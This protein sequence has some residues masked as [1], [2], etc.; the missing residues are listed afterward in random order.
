MTGK[1]LKTCM[2]M[3]GFDQY[4]HFTLDKSDLPYDNIITLNSRSIPAKFK[5]ET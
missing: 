4:Q 2:D 3:K 1:I 5:E